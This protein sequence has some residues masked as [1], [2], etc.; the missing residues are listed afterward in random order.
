MPEDVD[1]TNRKLVARYNQAAER[2]RDVIHDV[3]ERHT[4]AQ[5]LC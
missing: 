3:A 5:D 2:I 1:T 4:L